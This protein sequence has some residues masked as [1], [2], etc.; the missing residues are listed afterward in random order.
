MTP[1]KSLTLRPLVIPDEY[2]ADFF[3]GC[4][5]GDGSVVV[6]TDRYHTAKKPRYVYKRLYVSLVSASRQFLE[7]AQDSVLRL[8]QVR[9][10]DQCKIE[11]RSEP[12]WAL[13]CAKAESIRVPRWMYYA[14]DVPALSRK[15]VIAAAFL[16]PQPRPPRV[17]RGRRVV[18]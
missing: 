2:F 10:H 7:W 8:A 11:N 6:Y 3:R 1:A 13:R 12:G 4:V 16:V 18:V 14:P 15:R 5:D 17:G 9:R